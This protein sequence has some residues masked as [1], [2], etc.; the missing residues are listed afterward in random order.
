MSTST[1]KLTSARVREALH[2]DPETG[3]FTWLVDRGRARAGA[4]AVSVYSKGYP[5]I[6]L[7]GERHAAHRVA[8]LYVTGSWPERQIDHI[9]GA[10]NN[11]AWRNLRSATHAQNKQNVG[12]PSTNTTGFKGV[13]RSQN[14]KRFYAYIRSNGA[15]LYLGAFD[16]PEEAHAAY[17]TAAERL[18]G[19]FARAA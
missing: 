1:S 9:D 10:K 19:E 8:W 2:Y 7:D 13:C 3:F 6:G 4:R 5:G 14:R 15:H 11:N 12:K 17:C 16:T 18:H